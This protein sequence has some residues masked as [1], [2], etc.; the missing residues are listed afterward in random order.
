MR[1]GVTSLR[2]WLPMAML[3]ACVLTPRAVLAQLA[4][5]ARFAGAPARSSPLLGSIP[6]AQDPTA[7]AIDPQRSRVYVAVL[8][9]PAGPA[10]HPG[11]PPPRGPGT[12]QIY[13]SASGHPLHTVPLG[14]GPAEITVAERAGRVFVSNL[15]H[16]LVLD[17]ATGVTLATIPFMPS[18]IDERDNRLIVLGRDAVSLYDATSDA[19]LGVTAL[20][21]LPSAATFDPAS[22][23]VL[24]AGQR[25][26]PPEHDLG[27][28]DCDDAFFCP[29]VVSVLDGRS[30]RLLAT[31][32]LPGP[33]PHGGNFTPAGVCA[34][35]VDAAAHRAL[36]VRVPEGRGGPLAVVVDTRSG[37]V[38]A[39]PALGLV[40]CDT[41]VDPGSGHIS[42]LTTTEYDAPYY[43]AGFVTVDPVGGT[44]VGG[45]SSTIVPRSLVGDDRSRRV[46]LTGSGLSGVG[47]VS[48][49]DPRA[50]V[51]SWRIPTAAPPI[52]LAVDARTEH[53]FVAVPAAPG[54]SATLQML[55]AAAGPP[56]GSVGVGLAP[57]AVAVD[58]RTHRAFVVDDPSGA[59]FGTSGAP[60]SVSVVDILGGRLAR[61]VLVGIAPRQIG[62]DSQAGRVLVVNAGRALDTPGGRPMLTGSVSFLDSGSGALLRTLDL[63]YALSGPLAMDGHDHLAVVYADV[64]STASG[65]A[66]RLLVIATTTGRVVAKT[67]PIAGSSNALA[68]DPARGLIY[69]A[70]DNCSISCQGGIQVID[71]HSGQL[72]GVIPAGGGG[73]GDLVMDGSMLFGVAIGLQGFG[74]QSAATQ[75]DPGRGTL[76]HAAPLKDMPTGIT[77]D[78][79]NHR[80]FITSVPDSYGLPFQAPGTVTAI[81]TLTDTQVF[82]ATVGHGALQPIILP[83]TGHLAVLNRFDDTVSLLDARSGHLVTTAL[84]GVQPLALTPPYGQP[85]PPIMAVD[86]AAGRIVVV[87][88]L[89]ASVTILDA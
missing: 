60:G 42:V 28:G 53:L 56:P 29:D 75:L 7:L 23:H 65:E 71:L 2:S 10:A 59:T 32:E 77:L 82:S 37:K 66:Y 5:P 89:S 36:V 46:F 88:P 40:G 27:G 70:R 55:D 19:L 8:G 68:V 61:R 44:I 50:D 76:I 15:N 62:I 13:D 33:D 21:Y 72:R 54:T 24:V 83:G 18:A 63:P 6:L 48:A 16:T 25:P 64:T 41:W 3:L 9:S 35:S 12:L 69:A 74:T 84:V 4:S 81:D 31:T 79:T 14:T 45:D 38:L 86:T 80:L 85:A 34:L 67:V 26:P 51:T 20:G 30:G 17:A 58:S 49:I 1:R 11:Q 87:N 73:F 57:S 52:A 47:L 78:A 39:T 43:P 22:G